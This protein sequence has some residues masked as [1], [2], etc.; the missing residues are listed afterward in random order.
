MAGFRSSGGAKLVTALLDTDD[1]LQEMVS[2][3]KNVTGVAHTVFISPK[4]NAR[5]APRIKIAIDPPNSLDPRSETASIGLD[6]HVMAGDVEPELLRQAQRFVALN[7]QVLSEYLKG[8]GSHFGSFRSEDSELA[9]TV[10]LTERL[11]R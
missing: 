6:G 7:R 1:D 3:R 9:R 2:Y 11:V 5:H 4:G 10:R 8:N